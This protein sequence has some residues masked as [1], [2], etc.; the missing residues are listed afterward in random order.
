MKKLNPFLNSFTPINVNV[1]EQVLTRFVE[2]GT[3]ITETT[4]THSCVD[5]SVSVWFDS[6]PDIF[7]PESLLLLKYI[8]CNLEKELDFVE[9]DFSEIQFY[10]EPAI[11][12]LT[13]IGF[14]QR[15]SESLYWINP[16][17]VFKGNRLK[18]LQDKEEENK[19]LSLIKYID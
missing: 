18:Y 14:I 5:T 19:N 9:I 6:L 15:R 8:C 1:K 4:T 11:K 12:E 13:S 16:Y 10:V 2:E 3:V 17:Y 7:K